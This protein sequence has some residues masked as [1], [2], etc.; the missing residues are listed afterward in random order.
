MAERA[1]RGS[2]LGAQSY[3]N[4]NGV[5]MAPRQ[6]VSYDCPN[7]H[8]FAM[9]FSLEADV[10]DVWECGICGSEALRVDGTRPE[11]KKAKP[12][13]THWDMLLERRSVK[14]LEVLLAERLEHLRAGQGAARSASR[15]RGQRKSA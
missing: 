10:P 4:D 6:S 2:R 7:G 1:L 3:E 13:R 14:E 15:S 9:P 5:E 11:P 8:R 12:A